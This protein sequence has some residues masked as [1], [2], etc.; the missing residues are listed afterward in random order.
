MKEG[1]RD[2]H[3]DLVE[4][5]TQGDRDARFQ[6]YHL[7]S[8]AMYNICIRMV[9]NRED[10]EDILQESFIAAFE[11]LKAFRGS[12]SFGTWLKRIVINHC[13]NFLKKKRIQTEMLEEERLIPEE[14]EENEVLASPGLIHRKIKELPDGARIVLNLHLL[15]NYKHQEIASMLDISESTS[16]SQYR[17]AISLLREKLLQNEDQG[18]GRSY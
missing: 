3:T 12:A 18:T 8:K 11:N 7:Y 1:N 15:E 13:L 2:I 10:A 4:L 5:S 9:Q 17:R 6:L 16:K 14:I